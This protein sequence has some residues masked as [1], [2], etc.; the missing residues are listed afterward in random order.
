MLSLRG[1]C[2]RGAMQRIECVS[3]GGEPRPADLTAG[4]QPTMGT[5]RRAASWCLA[6]AGVCL[7]TLAARAADPPDPDWAFQPP[8]RH[9]LPEVRDRG[10]VRNPID[11]FVLARIEQA[12]RR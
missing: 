1:W 11:G 7:C 4:G 2:E 8:R 10:W 5:G 9:A 6:A 12:G 3:A